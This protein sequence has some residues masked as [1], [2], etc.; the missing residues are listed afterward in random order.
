MSF[1]G[2][3]L[4]LILLLVKDGQRIKNIRLINEVILKK[5]MKHFR[6]WQ[7]GE[8]RPNKKKRPR[9]YRGANITNYIDEIDY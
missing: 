3:I 1:R 4:S 6:I 8:K 2:H 7:E 5:T 9:F